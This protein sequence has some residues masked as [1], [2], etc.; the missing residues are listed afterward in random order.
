MTTPA[1]PP[2]GRAPDSAPVPAR[3]GAVPRD[4]RW[5][6]WRRGFYDLSRFWLRVTARTFYRYRS[7]GSEHVPTTGP[8][9]IVANHQ[10]HFD[11]PSIASALF[12]RRI[13]FVGRVSLFD[14]PLLSPI[15]SAYNTIPI[16]ENSSDTAAIKQVLNRL[17]LGHVVLIFPEGS[18]SRDGSMIPFKRGI[19]L[20]IR[21]AKC[22]LIPLALE[23]TFDAWP[24][25]MHRPKRIGCAISVRILPPADD[26]VTLPPDEMLDALARRIDDARLELRAE[27]RAG[28]GGRWPKPGPGDTRSFPPGDP[29]TTG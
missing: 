20:L 23:G 3:Q 26:L 2:G 24:R 28:T 9:L 5:T 25:S 13:D 16:R 8:A 14:V 1:E 7:W 18:R 22:P 21:R 6:W 29:P 19:S 10:S 11:P 27:I 17:S 4:A 12:Q 15:I